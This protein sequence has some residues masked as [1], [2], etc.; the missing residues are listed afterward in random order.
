MVAQACCPDAPHLPNGTWRVTE[1]G[2]P[3]EPLTEEG[4][5]LDDYAV[6]GD[7]E[8]IRIV[9]TK[10]DGEVTVRYEYYD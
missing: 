2:S 8:G 4:V 1:I 5:A 7:D 9:Y 3:L 6:Y 10:G